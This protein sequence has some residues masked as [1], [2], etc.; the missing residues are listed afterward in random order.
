VQNKAIRRRFAIIALLWLTFIFLTSSTV[1]TQKQL[2]SGVQAVTGT[3]PEN[4][5]LGWQAFWWIVVKGWHAIEF[6]VL[7][8]LARK[9]GFSL[10]TA[11]V[12]TAGYA[13]FD[14]FHQVWVSQR[15][16]RLSDVCIDLI[17]VLVAWYLLDR[18]A[19][20]P[21]KRW[22]TGLAVLSVVALIAVLSFVPFGHLEPIFNR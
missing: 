6:G 20:K 22:Q 15:G 21:L 8:W 2:A 19:E 10:R 13:L 17:G 14:E 9:A 12:V 18:R 3:K 1:V 7:Y 16:G 5:L 11:F 4:F